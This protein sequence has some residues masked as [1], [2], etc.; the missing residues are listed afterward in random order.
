[1]L[2]LL[3]SILQIVTAERYILVFLILFV[4]EH[5]YK[6]IFYIEV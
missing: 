4:F 3:T 6:N 2:V 1:M 5:Y